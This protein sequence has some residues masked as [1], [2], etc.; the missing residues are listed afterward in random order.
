MVVVNGT[1][2][3]SS[4]P[5]SAAGPHCALCAGSDP[6]RTRA[7]CN[8]PRR[9]S[10]ARSEGPRTP[11]TPSYSPPAQR[12]KVIATSVTGI[13]IAALDDPNPNRNMS[14]ARPPPAYKS[15]VPPVLVADAQRQE[16]FRRRTARLAAEK[17]I[18]GRLQRFSTALSAAAIPCERVLYLVFGRGRRG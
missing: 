2:G 6:A 16:V 15:S 1:K 8:F 14:A 17:P 7:G 4:N 5:D 11:R 10:A 18:T 12:L 9:L 3:N 13:A